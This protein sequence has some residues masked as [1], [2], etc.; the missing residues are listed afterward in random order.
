MTNHLRRP[1]RHAGQALPEFAFVAPVLFLLLFGVIQMGFTLSGYIGMSNAARETARYAATVPT[2]STSQVLT[3]LTSRQLPKAIPGFRPANVVT[4][5]GGSA[6]EFCSSANPN[7]NNPPG[8]ASY[9]TRVR[10]I[11]VYQQPMLIPFVGVIV[12]AF[13]GSPDNALTTRV[14]EEMRVENPR[15]TSPGSPLC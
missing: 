6:V 12:D 7:N 3:E 2:A 1:Q 11:A 13:D 10:V 8:Y 14:V 9:S 15:L 4:G 5:P